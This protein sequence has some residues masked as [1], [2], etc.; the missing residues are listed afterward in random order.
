M[1]YILE[2]EELLEKTIPAIIE[3]LRADKVEVVILIPA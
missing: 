1:G 3:H 2:P